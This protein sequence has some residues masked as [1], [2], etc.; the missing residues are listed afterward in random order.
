MKCCVQKAIIAVVWGRVGQLLHSRMC[1][2]I[3]GPEHCKS[4]C[5]FVLPC[6]ECTAPG[7]GWPCSWEAWELEGIEKRAIVW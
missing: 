5:L 6:H 3:K 2:H 1:W 7:P 4:I